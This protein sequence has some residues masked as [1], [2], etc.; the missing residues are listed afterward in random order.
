MIPV[1]P[2][3]DVPDASPRDPSGVLLSRDLIFTTR[4]VSTARALGY[5]IRAIGKP[6]EVAKALA[7]SRPKA[8]FVDLAAGD[9]VHADAIRAYR[10]DAPDAVWIAF[11]SHVDRE[12][13]QAAA[14]AGCDPV[15]PRSRFTQELP[16]LIRRFLG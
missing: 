15:L 14:D 1:N 2:G 5:A 6:D 12:A 7:E 11:G 9:L 16:D 3:T 8:V 13:L 10:Q 4:I